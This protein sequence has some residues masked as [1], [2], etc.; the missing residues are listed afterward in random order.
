MTKEARIK[1]H[2]WGGTMRCQICYQHKKTASKFCYVEV[3]VN[4]SK[5]IK[6]NK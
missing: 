3:K 2:K 5:I 1:N 6:C 4:K